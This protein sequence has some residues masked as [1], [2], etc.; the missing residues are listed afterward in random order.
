MTRLRDWFWHWLAVLV[1]APPCR[2]CGFDGCSHCLHRTD[3]P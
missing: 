2:H 3:R 1:L